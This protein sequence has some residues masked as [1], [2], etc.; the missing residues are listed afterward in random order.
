MLTVHQVDRILL[1]DIL[2]PTDFSPTSGA[3]LP[4][5]L[6]LA[7]T[8][9]STILI[10]HVI[11]REPM[12]QDDL[13]WKEATHKLEEFSHDP[14][15]AHTACKCLIEQGDLADVIPEMIREHGIDLVVLGTHGRR[16]VGKLVMGSGAEKIYRSASCPVLTIGPKANA[17]DW[18]LRRILCPVDMSEN[19]EPA[20]HYGLSLAEEN[21]AQFLVLQ[22]V[23]MVPWQHRV[24]IAEQTSSKLEGLIPDEV[25]DGCT[26]QVLVGW[27]HPAEA[28]LNA[29]ADRA[30]DL[31]VIGVRHTRIAGLSSHLPWPIASELI[32]R[33]PCPVLT[34]RVGSRRRWPGLRSAA[35]GDNQ[36]R[37]SC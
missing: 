23:P 4:F 6:A 10:A 15:I 13:A 37:K 30:A 25:K 36:W 1:K 3:G 29:A 34:V 33:A 24:S 17:S 22:A 8:Y 18:K 26:A 31:I 20:L 27:E 5:A 32:S 35:A 12:S 2:I 7:R 14:S 11:P 16:G 21:Q 19:P 9:G 28:I